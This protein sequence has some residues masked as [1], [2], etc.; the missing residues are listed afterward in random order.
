MAEAEREAEGEAEASA[1]ERMLALGEDRFW[2]WR[3]GSGEPLLMLHGGPGAYDEFDALAPM[4]APHAALVRFDQRGCGRTQAREDLTVEAALADI[5]NV[6]RSA[7][8]DAWTVLGHS[9]GC[10]LAACYA[11]A[12]PQ[13]VRALVLI[14]SYD[15][16][17]DER[18]AYRAE[19]DRRLGADLE[20]YLG[21]AQRLGRQADPGLMAELHDLQARIDLHPGSPPAL[22]PR[23]RFPINF[24]ANAALGG[25]ARSRMRAP[26]TRAA[27]AALPQPALV[28]HGSGDARPGTA[29]LAWSARSARAGARRWWRGPGTGRGWS[30]RR[31]PPRRF[32]S[33]SVAWDPT[34]PRPDGRWR[35]APAPHAWS[36][37][38][39]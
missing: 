1:D 11:L 37:L 9:F 14:S 30:S 24:A 15:L 31:A 3:G 13:R 28:V 22:L 36:R 2:T 33:S 39:P 4:L 8:I 34:R 20:R 38:S 23:Y 25:A 12:H 5:E 7:G 19:R 35:A 16:F 29:A 32:R 21:L 17:G 26:A 18:P 6:R 10:D 27:L